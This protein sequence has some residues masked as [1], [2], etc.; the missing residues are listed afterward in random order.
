MVVVA[1]DV[2]LAEALRP[3]AQLIN[4]ALKAAQFKLAGICQRPLAAANGQS[5]FLNGRIAFATF[6][7]QHVAGQRR[8]VAGQHHMV[9]AL[10]LKGD[11][12]EGLGGGAASESQ[13]TGSCHA[14]TGIASQVGYQATPERFGVEPHLDGEVAGKQI[15]SIVG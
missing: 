2:S 6:F 15:G 4:G 9:V 8:A 12:I 7:I 5:G 3:Q 1:H 10:L 14:Q 11:T 13:L